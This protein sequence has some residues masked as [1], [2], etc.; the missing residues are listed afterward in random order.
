MRFYKNQDLNRPGLEEYKN[1][2]KMP[3]HIILDNLR[4]GLNVGSIFRTADAFLIE[5]ISLCGITAVPPDREILKSALGSTDTVEWNYFEKTEDAIN[6]LSDAE[7]KIFAVEQSNDSTQLNNLTLDTSENFALVFGHEVKG[8]SPDLIP[9]L[10]GCIEIPQ[11]GTKHSLNI[12]VCCGI[13]CW[14]F[15]KKLNTFK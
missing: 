8:V 15:Y 2:E 10:N 14:E 4:S 7:Y 13:I 9:L 12:S 11:S 3:V 5:G 1:M 6:A